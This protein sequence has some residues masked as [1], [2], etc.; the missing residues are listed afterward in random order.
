MGEIITKIGHKIWFTTGIMGEYYID[1]KSVPHY[2]MLAELN[3]YTT[4]GYS[5]SKGTWCLAKYNK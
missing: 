5:R 3:L 2:T 1:L 4:N